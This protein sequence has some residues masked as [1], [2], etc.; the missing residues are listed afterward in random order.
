[1]FSKTTNAF[2]LSFAITAVLS[3]VLVPV[4]ELSSGVHEWMAA[5]TGHHWV[6]HG[7]LELALFLVLAVVLDALGRTNLV[8][9]PDGICGRGTGDRRRHHHGVLRARLSGWAP[10]R[11][12]CRRQLRTRVLFVGRRQSPRCYPGGSREANTSERG[13]D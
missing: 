4:K 6:T 7:V 13:A 9:A 8:N 10:T 3:A 1:M 11:L 12:N 2:G 5:L